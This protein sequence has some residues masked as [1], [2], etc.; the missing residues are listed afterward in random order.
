MA[1]Y[2]AAMAP[3]ANMGCVPEGTLAAHTTAEGTASRCSR[4]SS[5]AARETWETTA[6]AAV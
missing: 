2:S 5:S 4:R 6:Q 3:E 1:A